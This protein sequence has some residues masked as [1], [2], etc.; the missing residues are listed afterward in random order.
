MKSRLGT[1]IARNYIFGIGAQGAIRIISWLFSIFVIRKL[2]A[3]EYGQYTQIIAYLAIFSVFGDMG[4]SNYM[5]R[6]VAKNHQSVRK[7]F[8]NIRALRFL[9]GFVVMVLTVGSAYLLRRSPEIMGGIVLASLGVFLYVLQGPVEATLNGYERLDYVSTLTVISQVIYL[10]MGIIV[11]AGGFGYTGL[12][13]ATFPG[14][15]VYALIGEWLLRNRLK[16]D[17]GVEITPQEWGGLLKA[18]IPF[19]VTNFASMLSFRLDTVLLGIWVTDAAI[20]YYNTAYN[21]I[22]NLLTITSTLN[23]ALLPSMSRLFMEDQEQTKAIFSRA[24]RYLSIFTLPIAVGTT[25]LAPTITVFLYSEKL[26]GASLPLQIL[27]WVLPVLALTSLCGSITTVYHLEKRTARLNMINAAFNLSINLIA[28][29][30]FGI[31]GASIAT[32]LTEVLGLFQ[33]AWIL[34]HEFDLR[35]LLKNIARPLLAAI[36]MGI[37]VWLLRE[38]GIGVIFIG[39]ALYLVFSYLLKVWTF[40]EIKA[41]FATVFRGFGQRH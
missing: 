8:W 37:G 22:F 27:I 29:P 2:G 7:L 12:I 40:G 30:L 4:V 15:I 41:I 26:T 10:T 31:L 36:L 35:I 6:E 39:M 16:V 3:T 20:G 32:V 25:I 14:I 34:R 21:L 33:F 11:M 19:G 38:L 17:T 13:V 24:I 1:I 28:I 9:L 5:V 18:G 23:A